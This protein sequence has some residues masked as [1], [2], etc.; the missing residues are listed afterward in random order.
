M[1]KEYHQR[2][3]DAHR[4]SV[5]RATHKYREAN[6]EKCRLATR[7]WRQE[8]SEE[9]AER[10]RGVRERSRRLINEAKRV[11]C[12]ACGCSYPSYVMDLHHR[13]PAEKRFNI[14]KSLYVSEQ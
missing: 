13:N 11:P 6:R 10:N 8:H 1:T 7:R 2:W 14:G 4:E 9:I 12:R 3:R 5:R